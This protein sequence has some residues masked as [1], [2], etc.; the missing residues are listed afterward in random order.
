MDILKT[1]L[2]IVG[3][4]LV[5]PFVAFAYV[6]IIGGV[7]LGIFFYFAVALSGVELSMGVFLTCIIAGIIVAALVGIGTLN[8][9]KGEKQ[10]QSKKNRDGE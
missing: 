7:I 1:V 2:I 3:V 6:T 9:Q 5:A 10:Q 4:L 8:K